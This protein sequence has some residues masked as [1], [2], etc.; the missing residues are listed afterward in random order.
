[1]L[2]DVGNG[3]PLTQLSVSSQLLPL[4]SSS[5][6]TSFCWGPSP[7]RQPSQAGQVFQKDLGQLSSMQTTRPTGNVKHFCCPLSIH[8]PQ[9]QLQPHGGLSDERKIPVCIHRHPQ[10]PGK[11]H[12]THSRTLSQESILIPQRHLAGTSVQLEKMSIPSCIQP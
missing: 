10:T 12:H 8:C 1:M 5:P 4:R 7:G 2:S 9:G 11:P 6:M 3:C